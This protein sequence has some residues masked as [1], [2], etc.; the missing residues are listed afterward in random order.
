KRLRKDG[1]REAADRVKAL[2]KPTVAAWAVDQLARDE[3]GDV[4]ALLD[5][6]EAL[7][8]AQEAALGG[9]ADRLR[10]ASAEHR[11]ILD[12]LVGAAEKALGESGS[13]TVDKVRETL[14]AASIDAQARDDLARGRLTKEMAGGAF[15]LGSLPDV[16][17]RKRSRPAKPASKKGAPK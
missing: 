10:A 12:R 7:R 1:D 14:Q 11:E 17:A 16:P 9:D 4:E 5:S 3:A 6:V 13:A 8:D 15:D 2:R